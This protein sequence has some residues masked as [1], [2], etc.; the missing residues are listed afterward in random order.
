MI[1]L[2]TKNYSMILIQKL[3]KYQPDHQVKLISM[4]ILQGKTYYLLIKSKQVQYSNGPQ[5]LRL[6][7]QTNQK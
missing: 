4:N 5:V 7:S 2:E 6:T 3:Q 1:N